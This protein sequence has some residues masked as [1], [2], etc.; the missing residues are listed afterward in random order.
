MSKE[1]GLLLDSDIIF[2]FDPEQVFEHVCTCLRR[3]E[4]SSVKIKE[5]GSVE[6]PLKLKVYTPN[7]EKLKP[8]CT[9][10]ANK[11]VS[12]PGDTVNAFTDLFIRWRYCSD[13]CDYARLY[14]GKFKSRKQANMFAIRFADVL[15]KKKLIR[16]SDPKLLALFA[17]GH[18]PEGWSLKNVC[19]FKDGWRTGL[20]ESIKLSVNLKRLAEEGFYEIGLSDVLLTIIKKENGIGLIIKGLGIPEHKI[21]LSEQH[22][23]EILNI[24]SQ[25]LKPVYKPKRRL[26]R[27]I[28]RGARIRIE[29][30]RFVSPKTWKL[31]EI[32]GDEIYIEEGTVYLP[33]VE[34]LKKFKL[35]CQRLVELMGGNP[36]TVNICVADR[37]TDGY[38]TKGQLFFNIARKDDPY[39]WIIVIARELAYNISRKRY[40]HMNAMTELL[41]DVI[42]HWHEVEEICKEV[43]TENN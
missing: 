38:N 2:S 9:E 34:E 27:I 29:D 21:D 6:I 31:T 41:V 19:V 5:D 22:G 23:K 26:Q 35:F 17:V 20:G 13:L 8:L 15:F 14:D 37:K 18:F 7:I 4:A 16:V 24:V 28:T 33:K 3:V 40:L 32:N 43:S 1:H 36:E 42:K 10:L 30:E 11:L 39:R 12:K 25:L